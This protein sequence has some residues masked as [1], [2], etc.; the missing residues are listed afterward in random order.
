MLSMELLETKL[1]KPGFPRHKEPK[2]A[3]IDGLWFGIV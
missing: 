1:H 3:A 2:P